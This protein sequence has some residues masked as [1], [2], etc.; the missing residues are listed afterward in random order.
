MTKRKQE[1]I[2]QL[3]STPAEDGLNNPFSLA[4]QTSASPQGTVTVG[5][6][7]Y[8][9]E[10]EHSDEEDLDN[11]LAARE[12]RFG[13]F[14]ALLARAGYMVWDQGSQDNGPFRQGGTQ[15]GGPVGSIKPDGPEAIGRGL[16]DGRVRQGQLN[17][18]VELH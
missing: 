8:V 18:K 17:C 15:V 1:R 16:G 12:G 10:P 9:A 4:Q 2:D 5:H 6:P 11:M 14:W 13:L 3:E 7:V